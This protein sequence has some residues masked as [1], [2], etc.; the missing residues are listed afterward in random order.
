M[1]VSNYH[2]K[3]NR[4]P[5]EDFALWSA[6]SEASLEAKEVYHVAFTDVLGDSAPVVDEAATLT[7]SRARAE[8]TQGLGDTPLRFVFAE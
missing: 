8:A 7:A 3:F 2:H 6:R 1:Y 4:K 5:R